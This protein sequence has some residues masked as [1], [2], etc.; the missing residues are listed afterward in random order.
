M[1]VSVGVCKA[2]LKAYKAFYLSLNYVFKKQEKTFTFV[3]LKPEYPQQ[4][5]TISQQEFDLDQSACQLWRRYILT[6]LYRLTYS[7]PN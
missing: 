2:R 6:I 7:G 3:E 1:F 4:I 5:K